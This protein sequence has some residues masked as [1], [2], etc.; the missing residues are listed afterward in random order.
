MN[1]LR[2]TSLKRWQQRGVVFPRKHDPISAYSEVLTRR[3]PEMIA[4]AGITN[5]DTQLL[6]NASRS[7]PIHLLPHQ[8]GLA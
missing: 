2:L 5:T 3:K 1:H 6:I 4:A 8:R 7:F